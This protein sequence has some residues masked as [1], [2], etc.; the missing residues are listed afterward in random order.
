MTTQPTTAVKKVSTVD[1]D[2]LVTTVLKKEVKI[3]YLFSEKEIIEEVNGI[4]NFSIEE[5]V[6]RMIEKAAQKNILQGKKQDNTS[7]ILV[8]MPE[9]GRK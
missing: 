9:D 3:L 6:K 8:I 7:G 5:D 1:K 4:E 2:G